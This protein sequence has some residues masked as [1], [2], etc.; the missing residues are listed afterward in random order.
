MTGLGENG[1]NM[2]V[3]V[4]HHR[5]PLELSHCSRSGRCYSSTRNIR[6]VNRPASYLAISYTK[7]RVSA[8]KVAARVGGEKG[9]S[10]A[11]EK[12]Q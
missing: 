7:W 11:K 9:D 5:R 1:E 6:G 10:K 12:L 8:E 2:G 4:V 3:S